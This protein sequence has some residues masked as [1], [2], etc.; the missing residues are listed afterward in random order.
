MG[1]VA[2]IAWT[3][4]DMVSHPVPNPACVVLHHSAV[5]KV[6]NLESWHAGPPASYPQ[7]HLPSSTATT[8]ELLEADNPHMKGTMT[9]SRRLFGFSEWSHAH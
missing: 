2:V 8:W 1:S 6:T 3:Q 9:S 4:L 7:T 5:P